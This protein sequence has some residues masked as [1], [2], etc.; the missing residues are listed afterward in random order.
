MNVQRSPLRPS[1]WTLHWT[2]EMFILWTDERCIC[3]SVLSFFVLQYYSVS[4]HV[5]NLPLSSEFMSLVLFITLQLALFVLADHR[6]QSSVNI[7]TGCRGYRDRSLK[8]KTSNIWFVLF[9]N[10][11]TFSLLYSPGHRFVPWDINL[12]LKLHLMSLIHIRCHNYSFTLFKY[13]YN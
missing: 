13:N 11:S 6:K 9:V 7:W 4:Q 12:Q 5:F 10:T 2:L 3:C 8:D 1:T